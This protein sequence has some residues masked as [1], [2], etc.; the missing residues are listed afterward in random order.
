MIYFDILMKKI[1]Y[2]ALIG[3]TLITLIGLG[4]VLRKPQINELAQ[5]QAQNSVTPT[6]MPSGETTLMQF[7]APPQMILEAGKDYRAI[8][9]TNKG[10]ISIDLYE[11]KVPNTVNNFIFLAGNDFYDGVSFHRVVEGFM[12]QSGDPT[13][14]GSG[15]PGYLFDDEPFEGEYVR[16]TI[17]MANAGP[18]TNGSQFF[19]VHQDAPLPKDYVIFGLVIEGIEIVDAIASV[20]VTENEYG[21]LSVP[22]EPVYIQTVDI[23]VK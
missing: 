23:F 3:V 19:I 14:T 22:A 16:G 2:Y 20:E 7:D 11:E 8:L 21:E 4:I 17:A 5:Q 10:D 9:R 1:N 15:G 18:N 12:I 6:R 13:G